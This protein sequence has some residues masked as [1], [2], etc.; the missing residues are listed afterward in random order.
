MKKTTLST[1][2]F[3]PREGYERAVIFTS[4]DFGS[5]TKLQLMRLGP[6]MNIRPHYHNV[7][8]ECFRI[9]SGEG[10]ILIGGEV[11]ATSPDDMVICAPGEVHEFVNLSDSEHFYFQV[12]RTNDPKDNDMIWVKE[13]NS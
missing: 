1:Q 6:G 12:I 11:V 3:E 10:K 8:T 4:D 5:N 9:I 2:Q 13:D 7:R